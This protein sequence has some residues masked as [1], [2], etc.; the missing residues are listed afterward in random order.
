MAGYIVRRCLYAVLILVGVNLLTFTLFFA[1][2]SPVHIKING[3]LIPINQHRLEPENILSLLSEI[4]TPEQMQ[5]LERENELNMGVSR[6]NLGRYRLSAFRQRGSLAAV[7]RC[8][9]IDIP[10]LDTLN[11]PPILSSLILEK[12]GLMI[13]FCERG[14]IVVLIQHHGTGVAQRAQ[15][16]VDFG[17]PERGKLDA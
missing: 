14:S 10:A 3:N 15:R 6:P 4:A 2:N 13:S 8:I 17:P 16:R 12:R 11:L 1:V 7:F 5:E 9:P